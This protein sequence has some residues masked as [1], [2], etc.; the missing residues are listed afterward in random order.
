MWDVVKLA[1]DMGDEMDPYMT[2]TA[3]AMNVA[4]QSQADVLAEAA[5][6]LE[7]ATKALSSL[8][9][10]ARS[11][12]TGLVPE[13]VAQA[14]S[15]L[16]SV[17]ETLQTLPERIREAMRSL[18]AISQALHGMATIRHDEEKSVM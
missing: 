6:L 11:K 4:E 10:D 9:L 17:S 3:M 2:D 15:N 18:D 8:L 12:E 14:M 5:P 13:E 7:Q 16:S 1:A